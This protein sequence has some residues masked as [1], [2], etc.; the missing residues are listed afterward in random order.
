VRQVG[1]DHV[2]LVARDLAAVAAQYEQLGFT[3]T[4]P[5][6]QAEGRVGNRC[7]MLRGSYVE[8]LAVVDPIRGSATLDRFLARYAGVHILA[9]SVGDPP[10]ELARLR[11]AGVAAPEVAHTE[12]AVDERDLAGTRARF[13]L[14]QLPDQPEARL[15]LVHHLTPDALWQDRFL[16]HANNAATLEAVELVVENPWTTAARLSPLIGCVAVPD[17][18]A[19]VALELARGIV[20]CL[21]PGAEAAVV[22]RI[23]GL[24]LRTSDDNA[25]LRCRLI[26]HGIP[27][28]ADGDAVVVPATAAGGVRLRFLPGGPRTF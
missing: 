22:P 19:D 28:A 11:R 12:R 7:V 14:V 25:A 26:E 20:R 17:R 6:R 24:L 1:L 10:A 27:H 8:L 13:A 9:F 4:P 23:A 18:S 21:P 16:R 3:L 2:G 5:A 15:N